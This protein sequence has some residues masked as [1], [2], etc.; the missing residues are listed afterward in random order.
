MI[1]IRYLAQRRLEYSVTAMPRYKGGWARNLM[2]ALQEA[3]TWVGS[4][5]T[6]T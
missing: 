5:D 6:L 1:L 3:G 4:S 2:H